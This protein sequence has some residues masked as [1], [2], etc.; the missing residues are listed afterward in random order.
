[1]HW[2]QLNQVL[3]HMTEDEVLVLLTEERAS[4]RR[5]AILERLHQRYTTLRATRERLEIMQEAVH[6]H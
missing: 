4:Q 5:P 6:E 2:R 3:R 1:L